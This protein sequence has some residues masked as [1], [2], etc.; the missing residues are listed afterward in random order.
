MIKRVVT[1]ALSAFL[2]CSIAG[3]TVST[4]QEGVNGYAGT[5]DANIW[6]GS[7]NQHTTNATRITGTAARIYELGFADLDDTVAPGSTINEA[8]LELVV[9]EVSN[10]TAETIRVKA[11]ENPDSSGMFDANTVADDVFNNYSTYAFKDHDA[12]TDWDV[13]ASNS[14]A[15][16]DDGAA[17]DTAGVNACP[18]ADQTIEFDV[19]TAVAAWVADPTENGG[20]WFDCSDATCGVDVRNRFN[21]TASNRPK[22]TIDWTA[23]GGGERRRQG[24]LVQ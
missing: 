24:Q 10:C 1:L 7:T 5:K 16:V 12:G 13:S 18:G 23:A 6:S 4:F 9:Q 21:A 2:W 17:I 15:D 3:A 11:I 22:L 8:I 19:T 14:F 20:F